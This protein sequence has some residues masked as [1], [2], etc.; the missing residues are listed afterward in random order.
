MLKLFK[1]FKVNKILLG[2]LFVIILL[3]TVGTLYI[4]TLTADI[5]NNGVIK[6]NIHYVLRTG[7]IM[8]GTAVFTGILA[9]ISTY[10]SSNLLLLISK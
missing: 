10:F 9:I 7:G 5:I 3:K 6:G 2:S 1:Y 4:P 8:I